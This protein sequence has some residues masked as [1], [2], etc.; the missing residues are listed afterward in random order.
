MPQK[1]AVL[2]NDLEVCL[3]RVEF[4]MSDIK[5]MPLDAT[6]LGDTYSSWNSS[7]TKELT[8]SLDEFHMS[9]NKVELLPFE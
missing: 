8:S 2:V 1:I 3:E 9:G 6:L 7:S 5:Q 4:G